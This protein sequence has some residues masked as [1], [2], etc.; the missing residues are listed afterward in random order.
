MTEQ[1]RGQ[2]MCGA[3]QFAFNGQP[4]FVSECVCHS[5][6]VAHGASVVAWVGV[7]DAH[8]ELLAG[9][10]KLVWYRSSEASERG[11]CRDC[12]TRL[13]F[14]SSQWP[15]ETHMALACVTEPHDLVCK[16]IAFKEEKPD[17][18]MVHF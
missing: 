2:C 12:G 16:T 1:H 13:F 18:S 6:R 9:A 15:G 17:W 5:C 7:I 3:L 8:F 14:R 10:S 11:F 4:K